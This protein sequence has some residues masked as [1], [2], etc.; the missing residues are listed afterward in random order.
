[1]ST[2]LGLANAIIREH[3]AIILKTYK[4]GFNFVKRDSEPLKPCVELIFKVAD[5]WLC[6][7]KN[8]AIPIGINRNNQKNSGFKK[9]VFPIS[10]SLF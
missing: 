6:F 5:C 4:E 9:V 7:Q 8:Q 2:V 3:N 1:M 10:Y